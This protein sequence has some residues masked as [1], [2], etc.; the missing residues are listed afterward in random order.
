MGPRVE[1]EDVK[2]G[3]PGLTI[4]KPVWLEV[5]PVLR[6]IRTLFLASEL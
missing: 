5:A 4:V 2:V 1:R 6:H 3:A